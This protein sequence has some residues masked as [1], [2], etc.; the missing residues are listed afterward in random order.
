MKKAS[1]LSLLAL[2][3]TAGFSYSNDAIESAMK[4]AFKGDTSLYKKVATGKGTE[5]DAKKLAGYV[6]TLTENEPPKGDKA[7]WDKKTGE[8]LHSVELMAKGNKQAM[9]A[10]QKAGNCKSCHSAH[11]PD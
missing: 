2:V 1:L 8:L 10:V 4:S 6:K 9:M 7:A 3:A 11:K 5:A